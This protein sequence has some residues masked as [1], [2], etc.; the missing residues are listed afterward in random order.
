M[1]Q[2]LLLGLAG[3]QQ[4]QQTGGLHLQEVWGLAD[5]LPRQL[6]LLLQLGVR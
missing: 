6:L 4:Q 2:G 3:Q 5:L 1:C